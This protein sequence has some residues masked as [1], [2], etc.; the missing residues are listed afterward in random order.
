MGL[1]ES[2]KTSLV[3]SL[4]YGKVLTSMAT[5][6]RDDTPYI[7]NGTTVLIRELGGRFR[8]RSDWFAQFEGARALIWVIDSIDRGRVFESKDEFERVLARPELA[9]APVLFVMNKQ[10]AII[11]MER[12]QIIEWFDFPKYRDRAITVVTASKKSCP[13]FVD[14]VT[15]LARGLGLGR[16]DAPDAAPPEIDEGERPPE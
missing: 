12:D 11:K 1:D 7:H 5:G 2:G 15:W 9:G 14:G 4:C 16:G 13:D 6:L 8:F 10:D 3:G